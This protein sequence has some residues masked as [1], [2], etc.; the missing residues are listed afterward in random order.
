LNRHVA[1]ET[2]FVGISLLGDLRHAFFVSNPG[3]KII[4]RSQA[5]SMISCHANRVS[6]QTFCLCALIKFMGLSNPGEQ[7][8][9]AEDPAIYT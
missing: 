5:V 1:G 3:G 4:H 2:G 7:M 8:I 9:K 6:Q